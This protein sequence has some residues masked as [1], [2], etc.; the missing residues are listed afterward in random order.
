[1]PV[2]FPI[3]LADTVIT[4]LTARIDCY[5]APLARRTL[6]LTKTGRLGAVACHHHARP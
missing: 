4:M 3:E 1:M 5:T 6:A 2:A